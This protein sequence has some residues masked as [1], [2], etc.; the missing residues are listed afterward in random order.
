[1]FDD[2][3]FWG[4][5]P[6]VQRSMQPAMDVYQTEKEL[7]VEMHIPKLDPSKVNVSVED[8]MLKIVGAQEEEKEEAGKNYFRKEIRSGS[9]ERMFT[10]PVAVKEDKAEASYEHGILKV[11]IPKEE[12]KQPKKVEVKVK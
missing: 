2:R 6:A 9:F 1:M 4:F 8:G 12:I 10:L 5:V 3:D 7:V 11:V